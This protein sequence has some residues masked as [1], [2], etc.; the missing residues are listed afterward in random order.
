MGSGFVLLVVQAA[1]NDIVFIKKS[2]ISITRQN[3]QLE[4]MNKELDTFVYRTAH[5]LRAPLSTILG[6][7]DIGSKTKSMGETQQCLDLIKNRIKSLDLLIRGI[8]HFSHNNQYTIQKEEI[9]LNKL[10]NEVIE[11]LSCLESA[12]DINFAI[13]INDLPFLITDKSRLRVILNNLISNAIHYRNPFENNPTVCI[14]SESDT[15][16]LEI[17]VKDNGIGIPDKYLNKVFDMFYRAS[18]KSKGSGLGLYIVKETIEKLGGEVKV[19]SQYG[20]GSEFKVRL[21]LSA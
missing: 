6:L 18:E 3:L 5:D 15:N 12:V 8:I 7:V 4:K 17:S 1:T 20:T 9:N 2:R 14:Q 11:E 13:E 16:W 21:P 10:V 19:N